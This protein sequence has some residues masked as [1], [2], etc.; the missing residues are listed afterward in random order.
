MANYTTERIET[1]VADYQEFVAECIDVPKF[2]A[3]CRQCE[4][5]NNKWSCPPFSF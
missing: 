3:C 4:N 1:V 2:L 5:Y